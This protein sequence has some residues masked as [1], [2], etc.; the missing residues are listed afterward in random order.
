WQ[1]AS[2]SNSESEGKKLQNRLMAIELKFT[3]PDCGLHWGFRLV[4]G[5]DF[6]E[7]LVVVK[8][9]E[10]SLAESA[11]LMVGDVVVRINNSSTSGLTHVDAHNLINQA[12][13]D[14]FM[15][16]RRQ[17]LVKPFRGLFS[18]IPVVADDEANAEL[19][20]IFNKTLADNFEGFEKVHKIG[21]SPENL[22][23]LAGQE[24]VLEQ[25][26]ESICPNRPNNKPKKWSTFLVKPKNPRPQPK[27]LEEDRK[28]VGEP[29]KVKIIKQPRRDPNDVLY[30]KKS[31]QFEPL[32]TEVEISRDT[33]VADST[34]S[35][36]MSED[37]HLAELE[38]EASV[39]ITEETTVE[40]CE[41]DEDEDDQA[42]YQISDGDSPI[43][44]N[45]DECT[46]KKIKPILKPGSLDIHIEPVVCESSLSLEEQLAAVQKQLLA[47]SQLPSAI[48]VTL[49]AVTKQLNK[50][51]LEKTTQ[52][53]E[54]SSEDY[55]SN[56][57]EPTN[58]FGSFE[59][60]DVPE[61]NLSVSENAEGDITENEADDQP[62]FD[63]LE[64]D[65]AG[66][67]A[68]EQGNEADE[69]E[70]IEE[71]RRKMDWTQRPIVLPG[72]R[73]WSDPDDATPKLRAPKMSDEKI[74]KAIEEHSEL[75][76][77]KTKGS[78][79][80]TG[81]GH[82]ATKRNPFTACV[83][84]W[85]DIYCVQFQRVELLHG[86]QQSLRQAVY[87][88]SKTWFPFSSINFLKYQPPPKNLDYL[89]K[90]E[91]Y[92]LIHDMEPPVRGVGARAE[93][94]LSEKDYYQEKGAP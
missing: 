13:C 80:G 70:E 19:E 17:V 79:T 87:S 28:I 41:A 60:E 85:H 9:Q 12:G 18:D 21:P 50:I 56:H 71:E 40:M 68:E 2:C 35:L 38:V 44:T 91:V 27:K 29:Y 6:N 36:E 54:A 51:V 25:V 57:L 26:N 83:V 15:A 93:I 31:V 67:E 61:E 94:I 48:Q 33:S 62:S 84:W 4:G 72:G 59:E 8:V 92:R 23:N 73:K 1:I 5:A 78:T 89:Q 69:A 82:G 90:S 14:F 49:E 10:G 52:V 22:E 43:Q 58:G 37:T 3:K 77:G 63:D 88:P 47:L 53:Q 7:P 39:Q 20:D 74:C 11:G 81:F 24:Q 16:I 64:H 42:T 55:E 32:V 76:V 30:R 34:D 66:S 45:G 65:H 86:P 46:I 75:I